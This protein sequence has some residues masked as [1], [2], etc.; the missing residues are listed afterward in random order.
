MAAGG[1]FEWLGR[2]SERAAESELASI[3]VHR[4]H[5]GRFQPR[6]SID[7]AELEQLARSVREVGVLQPVV[8]RPSGDGYELVM[9]ERR[10]RA[11]QAA[12]LET[13]PAIVRPLSDREAALAALAEN[14]Q[15]ED[16]SYWDEAAGYE[17]FLKTFGVTQEQLASA[18][19][20]SQ[21]TIANKLRLLKL[22][23]EVRR[24]LQAAGLGERHARSLLRLPDAQAQIEALTV[25]IDRALNAREAEEYV[26]RM[27]RGRVTEGHGTD[28]QRRDRRRGKATV[29]VIKDVRIMLNTFRQGVEALRKAGLQADMRAE[30][31]EDHIEIRIRI[32]KE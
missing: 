11:A 6:R 8:V 7:Q 32:P 25:M 4:I 19:G 9:G 17:R 5:P 2:F 13:I 30:E 26:D 31:A 10:W 3:P 14:L 21:A 24:R 23:E 22:P 1:L 12:G 29:T 16:L 15:R 28:R 20:K 18:L 27:L